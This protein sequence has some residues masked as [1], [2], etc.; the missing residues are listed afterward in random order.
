ME[1]DLTLTGV[2]LALGAAVL[3]WIGWSVLA[4]VLGIT[5]AAFLLAARVPELP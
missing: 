4:T 3:V 1:R 2:A 5:A